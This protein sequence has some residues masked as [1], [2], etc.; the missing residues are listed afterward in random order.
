MYTSYFMFR[1]LNETL[2]WGGHSDNAAFF[3]GAGIA[4]FHGFVVEVGD[5][6]SPFGFD[7][8]DLN[9]NYIGLAFAM[10]RERVTFLQNFEMKWSLYYPLNQ[11]AFKINALYD[12]HIYWM[13][14]RVHNLLPADWQPYWPRFLQIAFGLG[15]A[16]DVTRRTY[17]IGLD[18]NLELIPIEG[19]DATLLKTIL[20]MFHLPAPG[21]K[22]SKGHPPEFRLL[23][24]N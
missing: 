2:K 8:K 17:I 14:M 16:D 23:L 1:A 11:H 7:Y 4:A 21:V 10:L 9:F 18:Y 20:N 12:Y 6:F 15:A 5:G 24:L 13:S 3:W 19:K 22:L